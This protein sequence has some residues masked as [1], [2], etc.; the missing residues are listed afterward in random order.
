MTLSRFEKQLNFIQEA[1]KLK[2]V[3]R[4]CWLLDGSRRETDA[5]HSWHLA[6]MAIIFS[7]YANEN[8]CD[9]LKV[10]QMLLIHD[11]V[12]IDV[13]DC[14]R[15]DAQARVN[16][17][18]LEKK[19]ADRIFGLLPE[20]QADKFKNLWQ[21]YS[22]GKTLEARFACAIDKFQPVLHN[23]LNDGK[24][25][26]ELKISSKQIFDAS[27]NIADGSR[28]LWRYAQKI[29]QDIVEKGYINE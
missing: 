1:D 11:L 16:K 5:E 13:G 26:D 2:S 27:K 19:A 22:D 24:P 9:L 6:L 12:E 8:G 15:Y 25:W 20:G 18:F 21:E 17:V 14:S 3:Y 4:L 7:E 29:V 28:P 23:V 10:I